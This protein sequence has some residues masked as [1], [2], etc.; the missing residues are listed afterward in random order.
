MGQSHSPEQSAH[1]IPRYQRLKEGGCT[2]MTHITDY[3]K[4]GERKAAEIVA[5]TFNPPL[6]RLS[7]A[8]TPSDQPW[9]K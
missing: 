8:F 1:P 4:T 9:N 6:L 3:D 7:R 2:P 5:V